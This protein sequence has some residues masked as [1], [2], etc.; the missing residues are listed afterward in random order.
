MK[1]PFYYQNQTSQ[2][3]FFH[4]DKFNNTILE[5]G[6]DIFYLKINYEYPYMSLYS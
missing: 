1:T 2:T 4:F 6:K 3:I 5:P